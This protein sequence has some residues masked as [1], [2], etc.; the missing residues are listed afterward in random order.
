MRNLF[1]NRWVL[2]TGASSGL[3]AELARRMAEHGAHLVLTARSRDRLEELAQDLR[4]VNGTRTHVVPVD[5]ADPDGAATLARTVRELGVPIAHL[6][7]NAGIGSA[8]AF[9]ELDAARESSL[10]ELNVAAIV[11]LTRALLPGMLA[12]GDGGVLNVASTVAFQPVPYMATYAA[13]KAFVVSFTLGL[14]TELE[15]SGVRVMALC[16]G[17]VRTGFQAAAGIER[18][19]LPIAV[20]SAQRTVELALAAY[21]RGERLFVPGVVNGL[22]V[23]AARLLPRGLTAWATKRTMQRLGRAPKRLRG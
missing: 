21:A 18:P 16:P 15:G 20:L 14:A 17:P 19:G 23:G 5:L 11:R 7:N 9:A 6:V 10:V 3:G 4:R 12:A 1:E 2:V 22:Q 13:T 8:G